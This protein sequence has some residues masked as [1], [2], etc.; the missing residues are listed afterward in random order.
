M[1]LGESIEDAPRQT[2]N[3]GLRGLELLRNLSWAALGL[4]VACGEASAPS[5]QRSDD[6]SATVTPADPGAPGT[7]FGPKCSLIID[8]SDG[9]EPLFA[10]GTLAAVSESGRSHLFYIPTP[11]SAAAHP[12]PYIS[13]LFEAPEWTSG[14]YQ[15]GVAGGLRFTLPSGLS[16]ALD[17]AATDGSGSFELNVARAELATSGDHYY[18]TGTLQAELPCT[19][20]AAHSLSLE[21]TI[22]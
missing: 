3:G 13:I 18:L 15:R 7:P 4:V 2:V 20:S 6:T 9:T 21:M 19:S 10:D 22:N 1:C 17:A 11:S 12:A 5:P 16:Y 8:P 14:T